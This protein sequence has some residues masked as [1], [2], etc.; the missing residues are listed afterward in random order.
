[1]INSGFTAIG[2]WIVVMIVTFLVLGVLAFVAG[3]G[4]INFIDSFSITLVIFVAILELILCSA[5]V[6]FKINPEIYG[7]T[8]ISRTLRR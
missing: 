1:M 8:R 2:L 4:L 3:D 6:K 5:Y 7:Y